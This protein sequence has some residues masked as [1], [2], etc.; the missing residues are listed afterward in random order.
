MFCI[1]A[2]R[3]RRYF[4]K[5]A[6]AA[7]AVVRSTAAANEKFIVACMGIRGRGGAIMRGFAELGGVEVAAICDV[8]TRLFDKAVRDVQ[9][10][11]RKPPR[12]ETDFRRLLDDKSIDA[13]VIGTPDH[14]HAIP[15]ILACQAGKHVYVE[16]PASHNHR[17]G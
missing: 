9:E 14:W 17:E 12:T 11:Q 15:T 7:T 16:K 8:D 4:L 10:R 2:S 13:L 3:N 1:M 5:R 6:L